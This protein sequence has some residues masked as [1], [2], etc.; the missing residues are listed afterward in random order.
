M[1]ALVASLALLSVCTAAPA[2]EAMRCGNS[3]VTTPISLEEL[4]RKCGEPTSKEVST[5]DIRTAGK[6]GA[7]SRAIGTTTTEKWTYRSDA[8]S[9]PMIVTIIDGRVTKIERGK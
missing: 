2:E 7:A 5:E 1:R 9:L 6:P 8:Q 4:L 3:V